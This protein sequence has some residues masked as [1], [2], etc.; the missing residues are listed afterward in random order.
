MRHS[1]HE[2]RRYARHRT[3]ANM[4]TRLVL[5]RPTVAVR[6][7]GAAGAGCRDAGRAR[8]VHATPLP[9]RK[10]ARGAEVPHRFPCAH[11]LDKRSGRVGGPTWED[12]PAQSCSGSFARRTR[13]F[14]CTIGVGRTVAT[15]IAQSS[16]DRFALPDARGFWGPFASSPRLIARVGEDQPSS[17]PR[18]H[19][20]N[21]RGR[22][23]CARLHI[24]GP[25]LPI[26]GD[27]LRISNVSVRQPAHCR[28]MPLNQQGFISAGKSPSV[29]SLLASS[30]ERLVFE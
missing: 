20:A 30:R 12:E 5:D 18:G 15:G 10:L 25:L 22:V 6:F 7:Q 28:A 13:H 26:V 16:H 23:F 21:W 29:T 19:V 27:C 1:R 4:V 11:P 8:L 9:W 3:S 17:R 24:C 2:L 14:C